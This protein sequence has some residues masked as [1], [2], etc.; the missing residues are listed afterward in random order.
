MK[1]KERKSKH[2][3]D[4]EPILFAATVRARKPTT[5]DWLTRRSRPDD[6]IQPKSHRSMESCKCSN[7]CADEL[8]KCIFAL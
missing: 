3:A 2:E 1:A 4:T 6:P 5:Q 8:A 7:P